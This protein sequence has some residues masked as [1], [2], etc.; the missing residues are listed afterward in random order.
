[1]PQIVLCQLE[2]GLFSHV[3]QCRPLYI[4]LMHGTARHSD[5]SVP[6]IFLCNGVGPKWLGP[7]FQV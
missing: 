3:V 1:M 4:D 7:K 2:H 6:P 5:V